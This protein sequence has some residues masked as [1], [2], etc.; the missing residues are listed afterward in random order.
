[1]SCKPAPW[2]LL[3]SLIM[4]P[5]HA[6]TDPALTRLLEELEGLRREH[7]V[8]A[9]ALTL[10][11]RDGS[12]WSGALGVADRATGRAASAETLVRIGSITQVFTA[13]VAAM[14]EQA[15]RLDLNAPVRS[16]AP[17]ISL[18]NP[19]SRTHPV[20]LVHL[21]EHTAGLLDLTRAEFDF[22]TPVS[23]EAGLALAPEARV[24]RWPPAA[25]P[26]RAMAW[27]ARCWSR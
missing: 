8:P 27:P 26:T 10:V 18:R 21:L 15:G 11:D 14:L 24:C 5:C 2:A 13:L 7:G 6:V 1:V 23:L 22:N 19:W 17:A 20:R 4:S 3:L 25:T 9:L 12:V 16:L